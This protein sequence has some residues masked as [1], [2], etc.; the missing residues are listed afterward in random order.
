MSVTEILIVALG[1]GEGDAL[2]IPHLG[3]KT[4]EV[5]LQFRQGVISESQFLNYKGIKKVLKHSQAAV[6]AIA[7]LLQREMARPC[8]QNV[9]PTLWGTAAEAAARDEELY[10]MARGEDCLQSAEP[11]LTATTAASDSKDVLVSDITSMLDSLNLD[12]LHVVR[13]LLDAVDWK[14]KR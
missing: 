10:E 5:C 8:N 12:E 14:C 6:I 7:S 4:W 9:P 13:G 1:A 2:S 11:D 3:P